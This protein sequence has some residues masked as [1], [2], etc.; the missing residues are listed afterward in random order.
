MPP[1]WEQK[2]WH[3]YDAADYAANLYNVPVI[4][5]HGEIDPQKQAGDVMEHALAD[6]N[7]RLVRIEG[8]QTPHRYHP[9]SKV[10]LERMLDP[11]LER[12][13]DPYPRRVRFT[14]WTLAYNQ[15]KWV[16]VDSLGKHW[17]R[18]RMDAEI[19]GSAAVNVTTSNVT[20]FTLEMG[21]GG[22]PL[23]VDRKPS[24]TIDGQTVTAASPLTDR[25]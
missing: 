6:E 22:C 7:L 25:S 1:E 15:V 11:I 16:T 4:E 9:E 2:L 14:T 12:G 19:A 21:P 3:L 20:A 23:D 5:Y 24:V 18:A 10:I 8:P 13:R 17:E